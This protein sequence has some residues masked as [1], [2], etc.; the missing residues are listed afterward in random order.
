MASRF[1]IDIGGTFTDFIYQDD[2]TGE[3]ILRKVPTTSQDPAIGCLNAIDAALSPAHLRNARYF[4]HG[5]TV[6]LNALLEHKGARIG[7]ITTRGFRDI[8]EIRRGDNPECSN[9]WWKPPRPLVPRHLRLEVAERIHSDGSIITPLQAES[10]REAL[11][12]LTTQ[13]VE[14]I[15]VAL[16]NSHVNPVHEVEIERQLRDSGYEGEITLS[17]RI[18]REAGEYERMST[19]VVD[20]VVRAKFRAYLDRLLNQLIDRGFTGESFVTRSGGGSL[21]FQ[22]AA[23]RAFE[24]INSGPAGAAAGAAMLVRQLDLGPT[25]TADVGGT[26]FDT[27]IITDGTPR[28]RYQAEVAGYPLQTSWIDVRS[29]GAG[30]GSIARVDSSGALK[31][32]PESAGAVPGPASYGRGGTEPTVT[33]AALLLGMLGTGQF[34]SGLI[35]DRAKAHT[36]LSGIADKL[37]L[38][39]EETARGIISITVAAMSNAIREITLEQGENPRNMTLLAFGGGGPL[40]ACLLANELGIGRIVVPNHAGNFSAWSLL[41]ADIVRTAAIAIGKPLTKD[42]LS[43]AEP[44]LTKLLG[45]LRSRSI[46]KFAEAIEEVDLHLRY[47]GQAESIRVP[48]RHDQTGFAESAEAIAA[49][50]DDLHHKL[51]GVTLNEQIELVAVRGTSRTALPPQRPTELQGGGPPLRNDYLQAYSFHLNRKTDFRLI[52][53]ARLHPGI[54]I[55]GP[56]IIGELTTTTYV[57][58]NYRI[59]V[60]P[61]GHI[62]LTRMEQ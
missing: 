44:L 40:L 20:S 22:E 21:T 19:T 6:G 52:D 39:V 60:R 37:A 28:L 53:R 58:A 46:E 11:E 18:S 50:F 14:G 55:T 47:A 13:G 26:S 45:E 1:G 15:A 35:L 54:T 16:L 25:V 5:S 36:A 33:D 9:I 59:E 24:T 29:I 51:Y 8:L 17:H 34:E 4:L 2:A 41:E 10:V 32:G 61:D 30:G 48:V 7:L 62:L 23:T 38:P 27:T 43:A 57:D 42:V 12:Y 56:A 49:R 3:L 31:V